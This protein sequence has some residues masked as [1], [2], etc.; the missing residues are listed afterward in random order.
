MEYNLNEFSCKVD[1]NI[2]VLDDENVIKKW[3]MA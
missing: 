1:E 3:S 2:K